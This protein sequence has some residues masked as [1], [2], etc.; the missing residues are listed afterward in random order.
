MLSQSHNPK[1]YITE[2]ENV[3][4]SRAQIS[5]AVV[6]GNTCYVGGQL[7]VDQSGRFLPGDIREQALQS[8]NNFFSVLTAAGFSRDDIVFLDLGFSDLSEL[9]IVSELYN[10]L[11]TEGNRPS[12]IVN[13]VARLP[14]DALFRVAGVAIFES[15]HSHAP[16]KS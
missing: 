14:Y 4:P 7:S 6:A 3:P 5:H 11:F 13:E 12:R 15:S 16:R 1:R 9:S 8:F 2:G 10:E